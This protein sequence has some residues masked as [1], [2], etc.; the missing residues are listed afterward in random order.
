MAKET[1][2]RLFALPG[3]I[4]GVRYTREGFLLGACCVNCDPRGG[5]AEYDRVELEVWTMLTK[6][7]TSSRQVA[8]AL[9]VSD[10]AG[11]AEWPTLFSYLTQTA[12]EDGSARDTASLLIFQQDGHLKFMVRDR[13]SGLCLWG[14]SPT[15]SELL[16][17]VELT[18]TD[19]ASVWRLDRAVPGQ[20]KASRVQGTSRK[21]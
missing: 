12:W 8:G 19:P 5:W 13:A 10:A 16:L 14:A 11:A 6:S 15:L 17:S 20:E 9:S 3:R 2:I 18:L 4:V 21:K 7:G 1:G